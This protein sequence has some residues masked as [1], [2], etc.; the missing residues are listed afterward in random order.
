MRADLRAESAVL[1][2]RD[3]VV[4]M[5]L[6]AGGVWALLTYFEPCATATLCT[7]VP[8]IRQPYVGRGP[9]WWQ[10]CV[11]QVRLLLLEG[12]RNTIEHDARLLQ[13]DIVHARH[14]LDQC[15]AEQAE[16]DEEI[17]WARSDLAKLR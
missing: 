1:F 17:A 14:E 4:M 7:G 2:L 11:L 3:L 12:R 9:L 6:I 5:L 15:N 13:G 16:V 8:L 10:R